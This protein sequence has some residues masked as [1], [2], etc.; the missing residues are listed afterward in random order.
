MELPYQTFQRIT[1]KPWSE[2]AKMGLNNGS[3]SANL[4]LQKKL[5]SGYNP[6]S[7]GGGGGGGAPASVAAPTDPLDAYRKL[8]NDWYAMK[9]AT[10]GTFNYSTEQEATDVASVQ[11]EYRPFYQEQATQS[12]QEFTNALQ[13]ARQGFS[14]R[15]LWGASGQVAQQVDPTTGLAYTTA[16]APVQTGGPVSGLRQVGEQEMGRIQG[17]ANTAFGRAYTEGVATGAQGRQQEAQDVYQK[18][19]RD[20]YEEQY[21]NWENQLARLQATK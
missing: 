19:I 18:T 5:L 2:A 17:Q 12:G 9:P 1:G 7:G 11:G 14:R 10:P 21:K 15:G 16:Q 4:A 8:I 13:N 20:P 3:S 6:Y